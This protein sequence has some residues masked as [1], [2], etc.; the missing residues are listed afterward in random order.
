M[1]KVQTTADFFVTLNKL[2][3]RVATLERNTNTAKLPNY[4]TAGLSSVQ[5][6]AL[7]F[8]TGV[9][10]SNQQPYDGLEIMDTASH[11]LLVRQLGKWCYAPLTVIN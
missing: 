1:T 8:Q 9:A 4:A 7:V 5:I 3:D 6:D 2:M 10:G 11:R